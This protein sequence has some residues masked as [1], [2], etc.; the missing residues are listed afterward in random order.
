M[1][2]QIFLNFESEVGQ[3]WLCDEVTGEIVDFIPWNLFYNWSEATKN[4]QWVILCVR[5]I[6]AIPESKNFSLSN[7]VNCNT[8]NNDS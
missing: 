5:H 4:S 8:F 6:S 1:K 2:P 7:N 3:R